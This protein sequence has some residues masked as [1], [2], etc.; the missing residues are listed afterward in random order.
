MDI[1]GVWSLWVPYAVL[2]HGNSCIIGQGIW[3]HI[4]YRQ[5]NVARNTGKCP[6]VCISSLCNV[7]AN[8]SRQPFN[9]FHGADLLL[10]VIYRYNRG[11]NAPAFRLVM[12]ALNM[13]DYNYC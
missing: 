12:A 5:V 8:L 4:I 13:E 9:R 11:H 10:F 3:Y 7:H 6:I 1:G 2:A